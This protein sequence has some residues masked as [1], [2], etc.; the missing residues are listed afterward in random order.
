LL[1]RLSV[2]LDALACIDAHAIRFGMPNSDPPL[3]DSQLIKTLESFVED[4]TGLIDKVPPSDL[5]GNAAL[6]NLLIDFDTTL[7]EALASVKTAISISASDKKASSL[8]QSIAAAL[9]EK[10][11]GKLPR[12]T[13]IEKELRLPD[14]GK[15]RFHIPKRDD[16]GDFG[17]TTLI[18]A[19][20]FARCQSRPSATIRD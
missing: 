20:T 7:G 4:L 11:L 8:V 1:S 14:R 13:V 17:L 6:L 9:R 2:A 15:N 19:I 5:F 18:Q 10:Y 3:T 12:R 16:L